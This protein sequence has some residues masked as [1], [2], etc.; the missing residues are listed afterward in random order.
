M[1]HTQWNSI[2]YRLYHRFCIH[3]SVGGHRG[4]VCV[5]SSVLSLGPIWLFVT[6]WTAA[7]QA[8]LSIT[9]SQSLLKLMSIESVMPSNHLI[10]CRPL[11]LLPSIFPSTRVLSSESVLCIR[12]PKYW[13]FSFSISPSSEHSGLISSKIDWF[14]LLVV[15]GTLKSPSYVLGIVKR[16]AVNVGLHMSLSVTVFSACMPSSGIVGSYGSSIP[17]FLRDLH[18]VLHSGCISL[19]SHQQCKRVP[20]SP[21]P[22]QHLLFVDF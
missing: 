8:S 16:T 11:L 4:C 19:H 12:W 3:S 9:N 10:L 2:V 17:S 6:P 1:A 5:L 18:T 14:D 13:S 21:H 7:R 15:Q 20:F 22:C